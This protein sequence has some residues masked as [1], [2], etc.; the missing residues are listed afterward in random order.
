MS[1]LVVQDCHYIPI[2][3]EKPHLALARVAGYNRAAL[4]LPADIIPLLLEH[5][6]QTASDLD[7][8]LSQFVTGRY[9]PTQAWGPFGTGFSVGCSLAAP[10]RN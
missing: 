3:C 9:L 7:D 5:P 6:Q 2:P 1:I 8:E 10:C 4:G